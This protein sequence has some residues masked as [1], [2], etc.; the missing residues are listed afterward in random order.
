MHA[1]L[2]KD[3]ETMDLEAAVPNDES[4]EGVSVHYLQGDLVVGAMM[5]V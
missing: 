3:E 5:H 2:S 4:A 1:T